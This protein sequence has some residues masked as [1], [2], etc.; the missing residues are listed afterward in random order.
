MGGRP[1]IAE[2]AGRLHREG[3]ELDL[4][5]AGTIGGGQVAVGDAAPLPPL[6][7]LGENVN[8]VPPGIELGGVEF[9]QTEPVALNHE[10]TTDAQPFADRIVGV[11]LAVFGAGATFV[12]HAGGLRRTGRVRQR[13]VGWPTDMWPRAGPSLNHLGQKKPENQENV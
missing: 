3:R 9:A 5:H 11:A 12:K 6:A 1:R 7:A 8:K 10:V 13:G 2:A 4:D